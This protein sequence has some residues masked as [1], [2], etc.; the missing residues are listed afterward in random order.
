VEHPA[1]RRLDL[2]HVQWRFASLQGAFVFAMRLHSLSNSKSF[3]TPQ[4]TVQNAYDTE[5]HMIIVDFCPA[6]MIHVSAQASVTCK[7][8]RF[9]AVFDPRKRHGTNASIHKRHVN[10]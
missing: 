9:F 10:Y 8:R 3:V 4:I 1:L 6:G 2:A 7:G 5:Y